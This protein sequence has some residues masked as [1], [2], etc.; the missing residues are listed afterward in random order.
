VLGKSLFPGVMAAIG[1]QGILDSRL[2]H[3]VVRG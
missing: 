2:I 3:L 1:F